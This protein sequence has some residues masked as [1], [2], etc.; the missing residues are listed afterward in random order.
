MGQLR[1]RTVIASEGKN[2]DIPRNRGSAPRALAG[3]MRNVP[4]PH[5]NGVVVCHE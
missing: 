2:G 1:D 4:I 3:Y 5:V